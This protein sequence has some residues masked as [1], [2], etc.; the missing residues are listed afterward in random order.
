MPN[1]S[2]RITDSTIKGL[3][4]MLF[5][6]NCLDPRID[7]SM[8]PKLNIIFN[9]VSKHS[10]I[11]DI[12]QIEN[13]PSNSVKDKATALNNEKRIEDLKYQLTEGAKNLYLVE[14]VSDATRIG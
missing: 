12:D 1:A 4:G 10:D 7:I 3:N 9:N 5:M 8:L 11:I 14:Q 6:F 2:Q 13:D